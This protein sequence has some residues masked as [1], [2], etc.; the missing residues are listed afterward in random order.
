MGSLL[1]KKLQ[2]KILPLTANHQTSIYRNMQITHPPIQTRARMGLPTSQNLPRRARY[3]TPWHTAA[4][5][6]GVVS[7]GILTAILI[8]SNR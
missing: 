1:L 7:V 8:Q 6:M 2:G 3:W 5:A 4:T